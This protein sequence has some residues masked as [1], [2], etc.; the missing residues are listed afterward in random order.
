MDIALICKMSD[1][2]KPESIS[3]KS[4]S[5]NAGQMYNFAMQKIAGIAHEDIHVT[6]SPESDYEEEE[7]LVICD[8]A[9]EASSH[10]SDVEE[11]YEL[12][13]D[14]PSGIVTINDSESEA[15]SEV[16]STEEPL[17]D[18]RSK[19]KEFAKKLRE[20][21]Q[22]NGVYSN[23]LAVVGTEK[24]FVCVACKDMIPYQRVYKVRKNLS[25]K[26][27][28]LVTLLYCYDCYMK[29]AVHFRQKRRSEFV[30]QM[31]AKK[32]ETI[33]SLN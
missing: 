21:E 7:G 19:L 30:R 26:N 23:Y 12:N 28:K 3:S 25:K 20:F 11:V 13:K 32:T 27:Y 9:S 8:D 2:T 1:S 5:W 10:S 33:N 4:G 18:R 14:K 17:T 31:K 22:H 29:K 6:P 24:S 15:E 16:N